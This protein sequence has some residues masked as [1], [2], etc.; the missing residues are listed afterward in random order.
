MKSFTGRSKWRASQAGG[1]EA[2]ELLE[3]LLNAFGLSAWGLGIVVR[4]LGSG[5]LGFGVWG[6]RFGVWVVVCGVLGVECGAW[7]SGCRL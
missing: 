4:V 1:L 5:D 6:L 2:F 7:G 3:D